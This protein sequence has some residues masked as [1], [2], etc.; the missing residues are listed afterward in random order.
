MFPTTPYHLIS[1]VVPGLSF[2]RQAEL[3]IIFAALMA[4][5]AKFY[6]LIVPFFQERIPAMK[7]S[8]PVKMLYLLIIAY[9]ISLTETNLTG[10][11]EQ[12][13][14]MQGM[15]GTHDIRWLTIMMLIHFVFTLFSL[16]S[17]LPGGSFIPTLVT[18][19]YWDKSSGWYWYSADG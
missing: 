17:G 6:S 7:L 11:G 13:L 16:S 18:E 9:A 10:G 14:M 5:I 19:D 2:I 3:Y 12:F 1:A 4:V 8:I 15:N